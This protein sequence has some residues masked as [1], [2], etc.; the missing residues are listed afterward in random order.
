ML[1]PL[2]SGNTQVTLVAAV[3]PDGE[4]YMD[5]SNTLRLAARAQLIRNL[6]TR[7]SIPVADCHLPSMWEI[8]PP[9]V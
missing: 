8:L 2:I 9:E 5:A 1:A 4:H 7:T 6:V 3:S